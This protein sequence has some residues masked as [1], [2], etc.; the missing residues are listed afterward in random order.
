MRL[1]SVIRIATAE[2]MLS[3]DTDWVYGRSVLKLIAKWIKCYEK[4]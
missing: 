1:L 2:V 4:T 3:C